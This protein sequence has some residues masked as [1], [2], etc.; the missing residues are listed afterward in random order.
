[1]LFDIIE[2]Q[3]NEPLFEN[4][5]VFS[6]TVLSAEYELNQMGAVALGLRCSNMSQAFSL[7]YRCALQSLLPQLAT[8]KWAAMCVTE[9]S[10]NHPKNI[11]SQ[12]TGFA[13][14]GHKS[15]VTM[16][17]LA[18]QLLVIVKQEEKSDRPQLKAVLIDSAQAGVELVQFPPLGML[19]DIPHGKVTFKNADADILAGDGYSEY[20]KPFRTLEDI[21]AVLVASSFILSM[22]KRFE[23]NYIVVQKALGI[24]TQLVSLP[25]VP[26]SWMHLQVEESLK[27][28]NDLTELFERHFEP[29]PDSI[30]NEWLA[31][32]KIFSIAQSARESRL[33][34]AI[35]SIGLTK[36]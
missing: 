4:Y 14:N 35:E 7:A 16:A 20:S 12:L 8:N 30:K 15:F 5:D 29:L 10:G 27:S 17:T 32:K 6:Q 13:V 23:I 26:S 9:P 21:Y 18:E 28:F 19:K 25:L 24:I 11:E 2:S 36:G 31:D 34:K 22:A 1:M 3:L 33:K